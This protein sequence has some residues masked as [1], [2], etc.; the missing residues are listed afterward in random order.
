[1]GRNSGQ[2]NVSSGSGP[3]HLKQCVA[4]HRHGGCHEI[5]VGP[6]LGGRVQQR[7]ATHRHSSQNEAPMVTSW[8]QTLWELVIVHVLQKFF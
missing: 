7:A 8:P 2:H 4:T 3:G 6:E 5:S 1:M